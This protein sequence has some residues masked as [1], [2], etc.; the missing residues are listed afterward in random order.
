MDVTVTKYI[1]IPTIYTVSFLLD[2]F[3]VTREKLNNEYS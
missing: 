3:L 1:H 2:K